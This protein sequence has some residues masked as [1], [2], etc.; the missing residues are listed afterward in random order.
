MELLG[1]VIEHRDSWPFHEPVDPIKWDVPVSVIL[2]RHL[3]GLLSSVHPE[4][5]CQPGLQRRKCRAQ[6]WEHSK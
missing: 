3:S 2:C 5:R 4:S 1:R 6:G